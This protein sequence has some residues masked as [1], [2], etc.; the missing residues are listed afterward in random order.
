MKPVLPALFEVTA[1][2]EVRDEPR[3]DGVL[4]CALDPGQL[5]DAISYES[6]WLKVY[7][8]KESRGGRWWTRPVG[9]I[10]AGES[11][12]DV[13][14]FVHLRGLV[15]TTKGREGGLRVADYRATPRH[16]YAGSK[17]LNLGLLLEQAERAA[18]PMDNASRSLQRILETRGAEPSDESSA[19]ALDALLG[20]VPDLSLTLGAPKSGAED[21]R[22]RSALSEVVPSFRRKNKNKSERSVR[23]ACSWCVSA[24]GG[25]ISS[26]FVD[27]RSGTLLS[28]CER[29]SPGTSESGHCLRAWNPDGLQMKSF[30]VEESTVRRIAPGGKR[31]EILCVTGE[32]R[33]LAFDSET[34]EPVFGL[35]LPSQAGDGS[36]MLGGIF[37]K[38]AEASAEKDEPR[39]IPESGFRGQ[40]KGYVFRKGELGIGYYRKDVIFDVV[41]FPV[42]D[43]VDHEDAEMIRRTR[44][45]RRR[46]RDRLEN[47]IRMSRNIQ[48]CAVT[49]EAGRV[50][51]GSPKKKDYSI[52]C[53]DLASREEVATLEGHL[54]E[55]LCLAVDETD[56]VLYSGSYDKRVLAWDLARGEVAL[57]FEGHT[58]GV[59]DLCVSG[60]FLYT[61]SSDN[62]IKA[63]D[64]RTGRLIKS[65]FGQHA[66][67]TWPHCLALSSD[68][69]WLVSGSRGPFGATSVKLWAAHASGSGSH[70]GGTDFGTCAATFAH[71]EESVPGAVTSVALD[72]GSSGRIVVYT[73]AS[74]GTI[75]AWRVEEREAK[76]KTTRAAIA[77]FLNNNH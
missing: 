27:P 16:L 37:P 8:G 24:E 57:R 62:T 21:D 22:R 65:F 10:E 59:H 30:R 75:A 55:V 72:L 5:L 70:G 76:R 69:R 1:A 58:A 46:Q 61:C 43:E 12:G 56:S 29:P 26:L 41:T 14:G 45:E 54:G 74:D 66:P 31:D 35:D 2:I 48:A 6:D 40:R 60:S 34:I 50:Y 42:S 25:A 32:G 77:G 53:F 4:C 63:W 64:A 67:G 73:G 47:L 17:D 52:K 28:G 71:L 13:R 9:W 15:P 44:E 33:L 38:P 20:A 11:G 36:D 39:F 23:V 18:R 3:E 51:Y 68:G 19:A 7:Y 49:S